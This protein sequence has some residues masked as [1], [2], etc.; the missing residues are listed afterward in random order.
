[1]SGL[2]IRGGSQLTLVVA[3]VAMRNMKPG[4]ATVTTFTAQAPVDTATPGCRS[5]RRDSSRGFMVRNDSIY[6]SNVDNVIA[7]YPKKI[8]NG[9]EDHT[10]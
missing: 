10:S 5:D 8:S 4:V 3:E 1:M 6:N 7:S 2:Y 9:F